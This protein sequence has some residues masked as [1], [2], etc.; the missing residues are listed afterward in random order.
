MPWGTGPLGP[1]EERE[2]RS[3]AKA[4]GPECPD[5]APSALEEL[6]SAFG[7]E[8]H[9]LAT[10]RAAPLDLGRPGPAEPPREQDP[11][12]AQ[13]GVVRAGPKMINMKFSINR[14]SPRILLNLRRLTE[15]VLALESSRLTWESDEAAVAAAAASFTAWSS[16]VVPP[17][18]IRE[19][20]PPSDDVKVSFCFTSAEWTGGHHRGTGRPAQKQRK[21]RVNIF[22][23]GKVNILGAVTVESAH[24]IHQFF[25]HLFAA[26]WAELVCLKPLRDNERRARPAARG[27]GGP[28]PWAPPP[29]RPGS[30]PGPLLAE[31]TRGPPGDPPGH[32]PPAEGIAGPPGRTG[33]APRY[34]AFLAGLDGLDSD[35]EA[36]SLEEL[37]PRP[38]AGG[39]RGP[40]GRGDHGSPGRRRSGTPCPRGGAAS[41]DLAVDEVEE[42]DV[43]DY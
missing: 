7:I 9:D 4:A 3:G 25:S 14:A 20:K 26:N 21:P 37:S 8:P 11:H 42:D 32:A 2:G 6:L 29:G 16:L 33:P 18:T 34:A 38:R 28:A 39:G 31:G 5:G 1:G 41:Q 10:P 30:P 24:R 22:Q 19:T 15:Y 43:A 35:D 17:Y 27:Q 40:P 23:S 12:R 36:E 13:I